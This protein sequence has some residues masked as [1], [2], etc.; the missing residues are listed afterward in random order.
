MWAIESITVKT[1]LH[2]NVCLKLINKSPALIAFF[3]KEDQAIGG[4]VYSV[5]ME[6]LKKYLRRDTRPVQKITK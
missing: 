1:E 6:E 5:A 2:R 3:L 4:L